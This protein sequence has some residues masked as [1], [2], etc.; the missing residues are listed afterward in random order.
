MK[1]TATKDF[2]DMTAFKGRRAGDVIEVPEDR[3]IQLIAMRLAKAEVVKPEK[4]EGPKAKPAAKTAAKKT[5]KRTDPT[6]GHGE[7]G[8]KIPM[9]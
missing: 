7:R 4:A 5:V 8:H 6:D 1:V 3:G 9:A 2:Y